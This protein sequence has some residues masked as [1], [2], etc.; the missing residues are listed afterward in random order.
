VS[1]TVSGVAK[2]ARTHAWTTLAA[3]AVLAILLGAARGVLLVAHR[4]V[5]LQ[6]ARQSMLQVS[7]AVWPSR[8]A[9][10]GN[11]AGGPVPASEFALSTKLRGKLTSNAADLVR[12]WPTQTARSIETEA[13]AFNASTLD[14]MNLIAKQQYTQSQKY[15]ATVLQP[16]EDHLNAVLDA[17]AASLK[18]QVATADRNLRTGVLALVGGSG[19]VIVLIM[20]GLARVLRR[21]DR[22]QTEAKVIRQA[23]QRFRA[24]VQ[25]ASEVIIVTDA[26]G[27]A[28][29]VSP[30]AERVT[31]YAP[32]SLLAKNPFDFVHPDEKVTVDAALANVLAEPGAEHELQLRM[33]HADGDWRWVEMILRNLSN[34][35][36]VG[37]LVLNCRDV[38][39]QRR[40]QDELHHQALHDALTGLPN[41]A[42]IL[43]RVEGALARARRHNSAIAVLFLDL[44]G[45]KAINDTYGHA[46]GDKL[47]KAVTARLTGALRECD[48]VGRLGGDEFVVLAEDSS[49]DAGP[50]MIAERL[51]DVLKEPFRLECPEQP[52]TVH[53][54]ASIGIAVGLRSTAAELLRDADVALYAAKSAGKDCY[55]CFTPEMQTAVSARPE[56][57]MDLRDAAGTDQLFLVYQ[58]IFDLST[59]AITGVEALL[60]WQHP[61]R[62]LV[63]PD[64]FIPLAEETA[65][66][67][68]IGRWVLAEACR[69][70]ADWRRRGHPLAV[71]V[72]ISGRQLAH[73]VDLVA[74]VQSALIESM[75]DAGELT[76]EVT[77]SMLMRDAD[78]SARRLRALK[79]LGVRIA[80]DDF[81][82]GYSSLGYLQQFPV[83]ALKI[84]RSFIWRIA[85]SPEANALIHT[86]VQLGKTLGLETVAEGIEE[87]RQLQNLQREFCYS[88][89]GYLFAR[90]LTPDQLESLIGSTQQQSTPPQSTPRQRQP[91]S[92]G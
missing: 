13:A 42:L 18:S 61:T 48:T 86:L 77:E 85:T 89:Q 92:T 30:S 24:L 56:L 41:R 45:F 67:V 74:D 22:Q 19:L 17:T 59:R 72:N 88:G 27:M 25:K 32:G 63:M 6:D 50:E 75:L 3:V 26:G 5:A 40:L 73:D 15:D 14:V 68:P 39:E 71:S 65:L 46:A 47:L 82:T 78:F 76:L 10:I 8:T 53:A 79:E 84:D 52:L 54:Q 1:R 7:G 69:Q 55:V 28:T 38:T 60:R 11:E 51:R 20:V 81:G 9:I 16:A 90:P 12:V 21:R 31:G 4:E 37:G 66:I 43:D 34:E 58:P 87:D 83:D 29:Y 91:T 44:D 2:W 80:I 36:A 70:A 62:G 64:V 57:E 35:P 33:R 23:E 49:L